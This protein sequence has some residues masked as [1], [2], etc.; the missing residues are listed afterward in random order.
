MFEKVV[1][2]H[3][4]LW[5][6]EEMKTENLKTQSIFLLRGIYCHMPARSDVEVWISLKRIFLILQKRKE[7]QV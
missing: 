6:S 2:K 3:V 7:K 5:D 1:E 4:L